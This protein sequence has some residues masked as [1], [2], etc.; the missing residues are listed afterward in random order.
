MPWYLT[1]KMYLL[2]I[3]AWCKKHWQLLVGLA[4]PIA[5]SLLFR[6]RGNGDQAREVLSQIQDDHRREVAVID[7]SHRVEREKVQE[8]QA[9]RDATVASVEAQAT[10]ASVDLNEKKKEEIRALVEKYEDDPDAL[11]REL[12]RTTGIAIWTGKNQ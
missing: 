4:I 10:A 2:K 1:A 12:S 7:E 8:A 11:T 5:L 9:R 3:W 6:R